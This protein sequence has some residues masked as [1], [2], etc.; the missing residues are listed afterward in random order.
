MQQVLIVIHLLIVLALVG[1]VLLQRSEGGA[2]GSGGGGG[3]FMTG[4]AQASALTRATGILATL[5][6]ITSL[7]LT[8]LAGYS[9]NGKSILESV[10]AAKTAPAKTDGAPAT[11]GFDLGKTLK[12]QEQKAAPATPAVPAQPEAPVSK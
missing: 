2:L 5:F 4:R 1:V 8:I 6:F 9:R 12:D 10:P 3:G 11:G 7:S